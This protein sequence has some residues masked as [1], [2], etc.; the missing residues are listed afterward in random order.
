MAQ[1]HYVIGYD[2]ESRKW[3]IEHDDTMYFL[4]GNVY[5]GFNW[6]EP[7]ETDSEKV[8]DALFTMAIS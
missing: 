1:F 2:T 6:S 8:N 4:Y 7:S 5:D 3:F